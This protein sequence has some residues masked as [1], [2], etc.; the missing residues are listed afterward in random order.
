MNNNAKKPS[1]NT[2]FDDGRGKSQESKTKE[3][4]DT[5][6]TNKMYNKVLKELELDELE[7][8]DESEYELLEHSRAKGKK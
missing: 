4:K 8:F 2:Y 5:I 6:R 3:I 1:R 7:D